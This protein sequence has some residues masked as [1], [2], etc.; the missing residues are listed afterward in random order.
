M[1]RRKNMNKK[2]N[3][4]VIVKGFRLICKI[5]L[6][7]AGYTLL[8]IVC[9]VLASYIPIYLSAQIVNEI[10][11]LSGENASHDIAVQKAVLLIFVTVGVIWVLNF[12]G[13]YAARKK[14]IYST[15]FYMDEKKL[16]AEKSMDM[17][18][19]EAEKKSTALLK[20]RIDSENQTGY[21]MWMLY[22][23]GTK[24]IQG[25]IGAVISFAYVVRLLWID[26]MPGWSRAVL[27]VVL[28]LVIAVNA[29]C[30]RKMQDVNNEEMEL[31]APLN[32][33]SN[34]YSDYLKDYRSGKDIRMFGMQKLILDN[35]RKMNDQY[36]HFSE[37]ANRKL[38]LYTVGKGLLSIVLKLAVYSYILIAFL[39]HEVQIG[40]VAAS[41]AYIVLCVR[42]VMEI[43]GSWQQLKNNNAYLERYF[44]YLELDEETADR[45]EKE[46][47]QTPCKIEF[48][49]VSFRYPDSK[50]FVLKHLNVTIN[51]QEK[52]AVVGK[53]GS[54]KTTFIKLLCRLYEPTEGSI[55]VNGKDISEYEY[56]E[57]LRMLSV[58]F[59]DFALF[60]MPLKE[61]VSG[62]Q[63]PDTDRVKLCLEKVGNTDSLVARMDDWL[64]KYASD[65]GIELSGGEAQKVAIARALY[66]DGAIMVLDEPTSA[67][68]AKS[69]E[70]VFKQ[71]KE[72]TESKNVFFISHRLSACKI[73]DRILVFDH[74]GIVQQ[75]THDALLENADGL[76]YKMWH[77]QTKNYMV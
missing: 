25:C 44:S 7:Y 70:K 50:D 14:D 15:I 71:F 5:N 48:R 72:I 49:D 10:A 34:F 3:F 16:F 51:P 57:Y 27:L 43:V 11:L 45:S 62:S 4:S 13:R 1:G 23:N 35:V 74:Q 22:E 32:Q 24:L 58:V 31:C 47:Q 59:Q 26:G 40:E 39:K 56:G 66:K 61:N 19:S 75:G 21:N 12:V 36:L 2:S 69:E 30:N 77:A 8:S 52:I 29:L 17:K 33:W 54:G 68:D 28:V 64:Y 55:L 46:V 6:K 9:T 73:C 67:M 41:V 37:Q 76:Y 18:F 60:S 63:H 38:E 20:A 53:N 42:D 65:D